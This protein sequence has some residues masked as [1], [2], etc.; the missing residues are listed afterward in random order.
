MCIL[1]KLGFKDI[2]DFCE[3]RPPISRCDC[4]GKEGAIL[5]IRRYGLSVNLHLHTARC[6]DQS[7]LT[8]A[9]GC[10]GLGNFL[11]WGLF[12]CIARYL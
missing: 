4:I 1:Q 2:I 8:S 3:P 6:M 11:Q 10:V 9:Y 12:L 7:F 5:E